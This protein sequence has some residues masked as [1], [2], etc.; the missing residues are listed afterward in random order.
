MHT[1]MSSERETSTGKS[2]KEKNTEDP[3]LRMSFV[4]LQAQ[5]QKALD[6]LTPKE[7]QIVVMRFGL[8]DGKI[9]TLKE[10]SEFFNISRAQVRLI[11]TKAIEMLKHPSRAHQNQVNRPSIRI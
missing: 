11:E 6:S 4:H 2:I 5:I 3:S 10:I 7:R 1:E 9:K 8:K